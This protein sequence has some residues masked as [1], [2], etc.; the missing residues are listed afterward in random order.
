[1]KNNLTLQEPQYDCAGC[2]STNVRGLSCELRLLLCY[3]QRLL[4]FPNADE[5]YIDV[6]VVSAWRWCA[7]L[8]QCFEINLLRTA[9]EN[10]VVIGDTSWPLRSCD[11]SLETQM[12]VAIAAMEGHTQSK[13]CWRTELADWATAAAVIWMKSCYINNWNA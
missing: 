1:M 2:I 9:L 8:N 5:N 12:K 4:I 6:C 10:R 13:I 11:S 7:T 3:V